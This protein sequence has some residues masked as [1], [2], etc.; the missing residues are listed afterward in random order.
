MNLD[1]E[2]RRQGLEWAIDQVWIEIP[3]SFPGAKPHQG[4][5][6]RVRLADWSA[7]QKGDMPA[8]HE[9]LYRTER[10]TTIQKLLAC[11]LRDLMP[12]HPVRRAYLD[13]V[14]NTPVTVDP[15]CLEGEGDRLGEI[16]HVQLRKCADS[17]QS[18]IQWNAIHHLHPADWRC[19]LGLIRQ[20]VK[21]LAGQVRDGRRRHLLRRDVGM[22][23][24]DAMT[25]QMDKVTHQEG[26][27]VNRTAEQEFALRALEAANWLT[28][29]EEWTF[30]W[31]G[32][33]CEAVKTSDAMTEKQ[34]QE[35]AAPEPA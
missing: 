26:G 30:S 2:L 35:N 25:Q 34:G 4:L 33:L 24:K 11:A 1:T 6:T 3:S 12:N 23:I 8:T 10:D 28:E 27:R 15:T 20:A 9:K 17:K 21:D 29:D 7:T 5:R 32:Y 22:A 18:V 31:T 19:M 14:G 16:I 13:S